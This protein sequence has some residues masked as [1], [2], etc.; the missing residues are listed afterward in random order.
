VINSLA[1]T[2]SIDRFELRAATDADVPQLL[3]LIY[4]LAEYE[5]LTHLFECTADRLREN[6]FGPR[7]SA[8]AIIAWANEPSGTAAAGF[9]LYFYN[10]S[11]FLGLK[12][13]YLE[14]LY[15]RPGYRSQ[16]CGRALL[17]TL[18]RIARSQGCGR[19]EWS[20]LDWNTR[21][22]QFYEGLGAT[23]L[24]EWRIVR[25]TGAALSTLAQQPLEGPS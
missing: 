14:D 18:A 10:F 17:V 12:G 8:Q 6:L 4:G 15:V 13:L 7:P 25:V 1:M 19:F 22:Q 24:P 9:A 3:E 16:G 21:A 11:T 20:V 5:H 23:V 2:P